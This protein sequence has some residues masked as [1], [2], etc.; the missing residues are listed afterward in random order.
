MF[1]MAN[2]SNLP[3][4]RI[5]IITILARFHCDWELLQIVWRDR[6]LFFRMKASKIYLCVIKKIHTALQLTTRIF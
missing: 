3:F 5:C 4:P 2:L 6:I 1:P